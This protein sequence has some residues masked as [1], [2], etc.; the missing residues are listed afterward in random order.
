ML[1]R[2]QSLDQLYILGEV[3][4][5]KLYADAKALKEVSRL[6]AVSINNNPSIWSRCDESVLKVCFLN[7]RSIENKFSWIESD[8]SVQSADVLF[9]CETWLKESDTN[10][11]LPGYSTSFNN[12]G[13]GHGTVTFFKNFTVD[14]DIHLNRI[15]VT[16][17]SNTFLDVIGI[18]I[19]SDGDLDCLVHL[20]EALINVGNIA[21]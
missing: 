11:S 14:C 16:K 20:L 15:N 13:R 8:L 4:N 3:P 10:L 18:Y 7:V 12:V 2:V 9:L 1:S 6:E 21:L 19:S 17:L 5:N